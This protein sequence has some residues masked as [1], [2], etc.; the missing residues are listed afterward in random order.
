MKFDILNYLK[1]TIIRLPFKLKFQSAPYGWFWWISNLPLCVFTLAGYMHAVCCHVGRRLRFFQ[2]SE[3]LALS[4]SVSAMDLRV[5]F[6]AGAGGRRQPA[7]ERR[8]ELSTAE[9]SKYH[10]TISGTSDHRSRTPMGFRSFRMVWLPISALYLQ[11]E[12]KPL[13]PAEL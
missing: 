5:G 1:R 12:F 9:V 13:K 7:E 2:Y 6:F 10:D 8:N 4:E 3:T 11:S